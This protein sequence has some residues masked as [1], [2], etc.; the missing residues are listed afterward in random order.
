MDAYL[1]EIR[2]FPFDVIPAGWL[3][4]DG[5]K[6]P[7]DG[8]KALYGVIGNLYGGEVARTIGLPN[9]NGRA[10]MGEG[11]G[12][13]LTN[14]P[15]ARLS[16]QSRVTL[17]ADQMPPHTHEVVVNNGAVTA[18]TDMP[19]STTSLSR[20]MVPN[21]ATG[22]IAENFSTS[23][24]VNTSLSPDAIGTNLGGEG[25][26]NV[27]PVLALHYCICVDGYYPQPG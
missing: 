5:R 17:T 25:H 27:Q 24:T 4:C 8:Y 19:G 14:A 16:G 7:L 11:Q 20:V 9:L 23:N 18:M 13:G 12:L 21:G 26:D 22:S 2:A 6:V 1:G 3:P 10:P 15:L